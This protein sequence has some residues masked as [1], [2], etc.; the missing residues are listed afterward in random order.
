MASALNMI[1]S[2]CLEDTDESQSED[3]EEIKDA[4]AIKLAVNGY[5]VWLGNNR[6]SRY[7]LEHKRYK[8]D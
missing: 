4:L 1:T 3:Q 6:G 5:D 8:Y 7:G 2:E